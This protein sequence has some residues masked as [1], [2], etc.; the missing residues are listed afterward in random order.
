MWPHLG[1][2]LQNSVLFMTNIYHERECICRL[3]PGLSSQFPL[4]HVNRLFCVSFLARRF[5]IQFFEGTLYLGASG[6]L[7]PRPYVRRFAMI[8][9]ISGNVRGEKKSHTE[10]INGRLKDKNQFIQIYHWHLKKWGWGTR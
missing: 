5:V 1:P 2:L 7:P 4:L 3:E 9:Q 6:I 10:M 8:I